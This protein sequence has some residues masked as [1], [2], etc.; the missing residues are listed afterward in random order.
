MMCEKENTTIAGID[1]MGPALK[2]IGAFV[3]NIAISIR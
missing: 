1:E 3:A 2:V